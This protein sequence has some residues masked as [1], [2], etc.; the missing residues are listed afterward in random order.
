MNGPL[1][2]L[3][4][5]RELHRRCPKLKLL[6]TSGFSEAMSAKEREIEPGFIVPILT[7]PYRRD[8]LARQLRLVLDQAT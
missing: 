4:L 2:G 8:E 5:V 1:T 7:K 3:D 6:L